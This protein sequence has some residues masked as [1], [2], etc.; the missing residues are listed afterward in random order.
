MLALTVWISSTLSLEGS[1]F[2]STFTVFVAALIISVIST[3][4][5]WF[6]PD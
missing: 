6:L 5:S 1:F 3:I 2:Q 4:L